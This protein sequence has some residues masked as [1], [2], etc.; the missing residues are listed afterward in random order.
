M[1]ESVKA[2]RRRNQKFQ[3]PSWGGKLPSDVAEAWQNKD[4]IVEQ[5]L[6]AI[7]CTKHVSMFQHRH[8]LLQRDSCLE[9]EH[10]WPAMFSPVNILSKQ[11]D[12]K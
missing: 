1:I 6:A 4:M 7:N 2:Y 5:A 11:S 12:L 9:A 3:V 8:A 10:R